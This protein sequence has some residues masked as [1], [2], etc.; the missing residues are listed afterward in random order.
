MADILNDGAMLLELISPA[1]PG[2]FLP[3]V[4]CSSVLRAIVG[5]AGGCT[6]AALTQHQAKMDNA[7]GAGMS[8]FVR[9]DS[10]KYYGRYLHA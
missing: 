5:V 10:A 8:M 1:F 9:G 2:L 6:R 3:I 4:C 7:G